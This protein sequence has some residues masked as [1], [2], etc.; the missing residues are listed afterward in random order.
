[1]SKYPLSN[2]E[3]KAEMEQ[4]LQRARDTHFACLMG[5]LQCMYD[6]SILSLKMSH[7]YS[8]DEF[9]GERTNVNISFLKQVGQLTPGSRNIVIKQGSQE[10]HFMLFEQHVSKDARLQAGAS[11]K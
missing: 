4:A 2:E 8:N 10:G 7:E 3:F 5:E 6:L 1:M 11:N 9:P